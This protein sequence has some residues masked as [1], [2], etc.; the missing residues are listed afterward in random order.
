MSVDRILFFISSCRDGNPDRHDKLY[1]AA[2]EYGW[3]IKTIEC[4]MRKTNVSELLKIW[5]PVGIVAECGNG[6][7]ELNERAFGWL[8]TVYCHARS[9]SRGKGGYVLFDEKEIGRLAARHLMETGYAHYAFVSFRIPVYWNEDRCRAFRG[10]I[11]RSGFSFDGSFDALADERPESRQR[12]L[13]DWLVE[14]P[15]PCAVFAANDYVGE[16]IL[17][18]CQTLGLRVPEDLA[19]L[20]V[21]DELHICEHTTP[22]L[23]SVRRN[24]GDLFSAIARLLHKLLDSPKRCNETL[25]LP[26]SQVVI[27]QSSRVVQSPCAALPSALEYIRRHACEGIGVPDVVR[28]LEL[29]RRTAES[30]F[31][32][33]VGHGIFEEIDRVRFERI[34]AL[35]DKGVTRLDALADFGGFNTIVA[36]RKA[37]VRRTGLSVREWVKQHK[38]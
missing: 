11:R 15:R 9:G 37:F 21:D 36:L 31:R 2:R 14:L 16:E 20:G 1:E 8:P 22:T 24:Y 35:L 13:S 4:R 19:V 34:F 6:V 25:L 17:D 12:R 33:S 23:S 18:S 5:K 38:G 30:V 32:E 28:E 10:E 7:P 27:R 26:P 29:P 3:S